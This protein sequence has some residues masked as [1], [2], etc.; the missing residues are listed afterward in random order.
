MNCICK[1]AKTSAYTGSEPVTD[2]DTA[3]LVATAFSG[4]SDGEPE[5]E[6]LT[7]ADN[8]SVE[9]FAGKADIYSF[10]DLK[11]FID[12]LSSFDE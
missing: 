7:G 11:S 1:I 2:D 9:L 5:R 8:E 3:V 4:L 12:T 10:V 6:S